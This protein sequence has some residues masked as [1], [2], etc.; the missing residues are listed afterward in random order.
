MN[1][2]VEIKK[3]RDHH[4]ELQQLLRIKDKTRIHYLEEMVSILVA[5]IDGGNLS[6]EAINEAREIAGDRK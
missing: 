2:V 3:A 1:K 4:E 6:A 5:G